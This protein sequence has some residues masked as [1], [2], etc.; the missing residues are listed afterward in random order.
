MVIF[1]NAQRGNNL[2]IPQYTQLYSSKKNKREFKGALT[3]SAS[4][5]NS[6]MNMV[7]YH[8][9]KKT[10]HGGPQILKFEIQ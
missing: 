7:K 1:K 8:D 6:D 3:N 9:G 5:D 10:N 4:F 2:S